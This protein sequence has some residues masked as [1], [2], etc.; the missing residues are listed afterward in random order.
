MAATKIGVVEIHS[1]IAGSNVVFPVDLALDIT[2]NEKEVTVEVITDV[3]MG[4]LQ[5][6]FDTIAKSFPLPHDDSGYGTKIL[7]SL[8]SASITAAGDVASLSFS[9]NV[10]VWQ[11]EK[12]VPLGGTT[13]ESRME[14]VKLPLIGEV[15]T[16]IPYNIE[17]KPGDDIKTRLIKE[18]IDARINIALFTS[19]GKSLEVKVLHSD[20]KPRGDIGRFF[21]E[22]ASIFNYSLGDIARREIVEIIDDG[23]LRKALPKE[24]EQYNPVIKTANFKTT[25]A[26]K[27]GV[28]VQFVASLTSEQL[29]EWIAK[30]VSP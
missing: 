23:T 6:G 24:L 3:D 20:V 1:S 5:D 13:I 16:K 29:K 2:T 14:C 19:N 30:S 9:A 22:I 7:A 26:G 11:I 4:N 8:N 18:D 28:S 17:V 12:G 21:N 10:A 25:A 15:C 27:L